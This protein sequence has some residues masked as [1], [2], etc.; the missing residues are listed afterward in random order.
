MRAT[1]ER[2]GLPQPVDLTEPA[3]GD[4]YDELPLWSAPFALLLLERVALAPGLT[5]VDVGAGTGFLSLELAQRCGPDSTV[6]AV[7]PWAAACARLRRKLAYLAVEN[8]HVLEQ[9]A[10]ELDLAPGTVD[11]VVSN[12]GVNNFENAAAVLGACRR[13]LK[14]DGRLVLTTNLVGHMQELYDEFRATL[15]ALDLR[16]RVPLLEAHVAHRATIESTTALLAAAGFA[17]VH[18]E[19]NEFHLRFA[20]G[21]A[22]FAHH[23]M[24]LGFVPAWIDLLAPEDAPRVIGRLIARLDAIAERDGEVALTIPMALVEAAPAPESR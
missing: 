16:D 4:Y 13:V 1:N 8:V 20:N 17:V 11:L 2:T 21:T 7:D 19:T 14:P 24:R 23:F 12:L 22:L 5:I 10:A 9:D 18:A 6:Y 3:F 15:L